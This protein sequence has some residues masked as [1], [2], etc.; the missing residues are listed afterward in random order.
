LVKKI[1]WFTNAFEAIVDET[2]WQLI[3]LVVNISAIFFVLSRLNLWL[4]LGILIWVFIFMA[5][6][7]LF[8]IFK[9]K[10]DI[11]RSEAETAITGLLSDTITNNANV[12]LFNGYSREIDNYSQAAD[13]LK[14]I[15]GLSWRFSNIF[16]S[17]Q[18]LLMTILE[19]TIFYIAIKLW[20]KNI[21]TVGDFVLIQAYLLNIFMRLWDFGN[22]IRRIYA[23]LADAEEMTEILNIEHE[24]K[25]IK[26]AKK[27]VVTK[28]E[29]EFKDVIFNY[30][31]T[32]SIFNKFNL[33]INSG[34][35][36]AIIGPSG[37]GK[38]T[39]VKLILRM[40][41][42]DGGKIL[43]DNQV[44]TRVTQESL[45]QNISLVPQD[46]ILFHRT[47]M[48]NIRYGKPD[49]TDQEVYSASQAA[50]C[51]QFIEETS[52]GYK[53]YVGERGI[54]LSGGERQRIAIARAILRN[55]P[56]LIL[57]EATSSLDSKSEKLIQDALDNLMKNKTVVVIAHRL[58]TIRKMDRIV[59][60]SKG[61]VSEEGSHDQ[62]I[63]KLDGLYKKLWE[64]QAGGFIK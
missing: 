63:K 42:L 11:E 44:I 26:T 37:A 48:E 38:T 9:L 60:V 64:L 57:D 47:L 43:I 36:L 7:W 8:I 59:V 28:G 15:R 40:Y 21:L 1:K 25:D 13:K 17:I 27:L 20:S 5:V 31:Q 4:G 62:L 19:I 2:I 56:I 29:I 50:N 23:N 18:G 32:R 55:A 61:L 16:D 10:Y 6:N 34:E 54:K 51:H 39:I 3:P 12:K 14:S 46:P 45:W 53:T 24:V 22:V 30:N 58:S 33:T 41:N 49:A 35:R 52:D